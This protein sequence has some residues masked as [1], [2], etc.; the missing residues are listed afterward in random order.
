MVSSALWRCLYYFFLSSSI[1]AKSDDHFLKLMRPLQESIP[2]LPSYLELFDRSS[3]NTA[4]TSAGRRRTVADMDC[5]G[6]QGPEDSIESSCDAYRYNVLRGLLPDMTEVRKENSSMTDVFNS[7]YPEFYT[8]NSTPKDPGSLMKD[9]YQLRM[10]TFGGMDPDTRK[11]EP[12]LIRRV[13]EGTNE[14]KNLH[15]LIEASVDTVWS[16]INITQTAVAERLYN[17]VFLVATATQ[18]FLQDLQSK[19]Q[20]IMTMYTGNLVRDISDVNNKLLNISSTI[21]STQ[22][23]INKGGKELYEDVDE[24]LPSLSDKIDDLVDQYESV[25]EKFRSLS[26]VNDNIIDDME[27]KTESIASFGLESAEASIEKFAS[28]FSESLEQFLHGFF[29]AQ[30]DQADIGFNLMS[31]IAVNR[32]RE[33]LESINKRKS[34]SQ[35]NRAS[36]ADQ[37]STMKSAISLQIAN[38][39][40]ARADQMRSASALIAAIGSAATLSAD[41]FAASKRELDAKIDSLETV[42]NSTLSNT[43][44]DLSDSIQE[45]SQEAKNGFNAGVGSLSSL[46]QKFASTIGQQSLMSQNSVSRSDD[47]AATSL[48]QSS[49]DI[50]DQVKLFSTNNLLSDAKIQFFADQTSGAVKAQL[51]PLYDQVGLLGSSSIQLSTD[52]AHNEKSAKTDVSRLRSVWDATDVDAILASSSDIDESIA[53]SRFSLVDKMNSSISGVSSASTSLSSSLSSLTRAQSDIYSVADKFTGPRLGDAASNLHD[54]DSLTVNQFG[55]RM[56]DAVK[57]V[58]SGMEDEERK[59]EDSLASKQG[60][61]KTKLSSLMSRLAKNI[62]Q[63]G[64][65]YG[66]SGMSQETLRAIS[67]IESGIA[68]LTTTQ[69]GIEKKVKVSMEEFSRS[70]ES[71]FG[72][73]MRQ[74]RKK[75]KAS[76]DRVHA[77]MTD[78]FSM[79]SRDFD[80][81]VRAIMTRWDMDKLEHDVGKDIS[82]LNDDVVPIE[83]VLN[84]TIG[85]FLSAIP[86][87]YGPFAAE[88]SAVVEEEGLKLNHTVRDDETESREEISEMTN[89]FNKRVSSVAATVDDSMSRASD[90]WANATIALENLKAGDLSGSAKVADIGTSSNEAMNKILQSIESLV[91][92]TSPKKTVS[93]NGTDTTNLSSLVNRIERDSDSI[94]LKSVMNDNFQSSQNLANQL[95]ATAN[96]SLGN[97]ATVL[98]Q[99][100]EQSQFGLDSSNGTLSRLES[101]SKTSV[102]SALSVEMDTSIA[103][104]S[105]LD[106]MHQSNK[107]QESVMSD[108]GKNISV[109]SDSMSRLANSTF[110]HSEQ[111]VSATSQLYALQMSQVQKFVRNTYQAFSRYMD[112]ENSKFEKMANNDRVS[113]Q[114]M[115]NAVVNGLASGGNSINA[116]D[117]RLKNLTA[118]I[119]EEGMKVKDFRDETDSKFISI[120]EKIANLSKDVSVDSTSVSDLIEGG[121]KSAIESWGSSNS[122]IASSLE[123]FYAGLDKIETQTLAD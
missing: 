63:G 4:A 112:Y 79:V 103:V 23:E 13:Y 115:E 101:M 65:E 59:F 28:T 43:A 113:L 15:G 68:N 98:T 123:S 84:D 72:A 16:N 57:S 100:S 26:D 69:D 31:T 1:Y 47:S 53:D 54:V 105:I 104:N 27:T 56:K 108:L 52:I 60:G 30:E 14:L 24:L 18:K 6:T 96:T 21:C 120:G 116:T 62:N 94:A 51:S 110:A 7:L 71:K 85:G 49:S 109:F 19:S 39:S 121:N 61:V 12:G 25:L 111:D 29:S 41:E 64:G 107:Q 99:E 11:P 119:S 17:Q 102:G 118:E 82:D 88:T 74:A 9:M 76:V 42:V 83:A 5:E 32:T 86:E 70:A 20:K 95:K 50:G 40:N 3:Q 90:S 73:D 8:V 75:I 87:V 38:V 77:K 106:E 55:S 81:R 97:V 44:G 89:S 80:A 78:N 35:T 45:A 33:L 122:T 114:Y 10:V 58:K 92:K 2:S 22:D 37:L 117:S 34:T 46:R 48:F 36:F 93:A 67:A 66:A 91:S